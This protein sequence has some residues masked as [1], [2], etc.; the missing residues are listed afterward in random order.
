MRLFVQKCV[1]VRG[2]VSAFDMLISKSVE[3]YT[4]LKGVVHFS[5]KGVI[6]L[7]RHIFNPWDY[8][9]TWPHIACKTLLRVYRKGSDVYV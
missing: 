3:I 4:F 2:K 9:F 5:R 1:S 7:F 6:H 8:F